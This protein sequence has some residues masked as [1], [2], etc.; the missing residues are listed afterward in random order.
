MAWLKEVIEKQKGVSRMGSIPAFQ[1]FMLFG[2]KNDNEAGLPEIWK[3]NGDKN[4]EW[5]DTQKTSSVYD[6][7]EHEGKAAIFVGASPILNKSWE[8]L[9]DIDDRFII[10][11][12]NSSAKFLTDR[13][14]IPD[15]VILLDGRKGD[16]SMDLGEKAR[17]ITAIFSAC[18]EPEAMRNW[19]GKIM[20][21]PYGVA[22]D[23]LRLM[24]EDRWGKGIASGGNALNSAVAIFVLMTDVKIMLFAGNELSFKKTYYADRPSNN[25]KLAYFPTKNIYREEVKTFIPLYEYKVWL[26]NVMEQLYPEYHFCNCSE[27]ILG[28]DVDGSI[29]P[30]LCHK[31]LALAIA[32]VKDAFK[33][34]QLP[35]NDKLKFIYDHFYEHDYGNLQRGKGIWKYAIQY[36]SLKKGLDVGCGRANGVQYAREQGYDVYGCDMSESAKKCWTE[37]GVLDYCTVCPADRMPYQDNEFDFIV[38]SEVMEH[39][40]EDSILPSLKEIFRIGSDKYLFTIALKPE[41]IPIGGYIQT[42][43]TL[44]SPEWWFQKFEEAGY[45]IAAGAHNT[46]VSGFT[47]LAVKDDSLYVKG[48]K[49]FPRNPDGEI[50]LIVLGTVD[51]PAPDFFEEDI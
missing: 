5:L 34:E 46:N 44:K 47:V 48:E 25:D 4:I 18:A 31:P 17:N 50:K 39:I 41:G 30:F 24:I 19:Q 28:V 8:A 33:V 42:H 2:N 16:W 43:I 37:R 40:P 51:S 3:I 1:N 21:V 35:L 15:Y 9:K 22:E 23:K 49:S 14:I 29:L 27:G 6:M 36:F 10:V 12:T 20:I 45:K 11:A 26:E 32:E 38:C 7:P 13:D